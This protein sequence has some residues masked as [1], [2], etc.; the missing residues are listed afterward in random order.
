MEEQKPNPLYTQYLTSAVWEHR[1]LLARPAPWAAV[2]STLKINKLVGIWPDRI[3]EGRQFAAFRR[4]HLGLIATRS[5]PRV[6]A[7]V[8]PPEMRGNSP[9][10]TTAAASLAHELFEAKDERPLDMSKRCYWVGRPHGLMIDSINETCWRAMV[11]RTRSRPSLKKTNPSA[12]RCAGAG[13]TDI[14]GGLLM[15]EVDQTA[16]Y[17]V[18]P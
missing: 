5:L 11:C 1:V 16:T 3:D 14:N 8:L 4:L 15:P 13:L 9:H 7:E 18:V 6:L 12:R 2:G 10:R 17:S